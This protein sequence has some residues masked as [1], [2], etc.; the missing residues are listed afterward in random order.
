MGVRVRMGMKAIKN[1]SR[2]NKVVHA[3]TSDVKHHIV[4]TPNL[5][6]ASPAKLGGHFPKLE[7]RRYR[8]ASVSDEDPVH[9]SVIPNAASNGRFPVHGIAFSLDP[10]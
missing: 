8:P 6:H 1:I 4:N 7:H 2:R 5:F 10:G 3:K 9:V